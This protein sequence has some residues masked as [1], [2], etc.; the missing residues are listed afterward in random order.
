MS[1]FDTDGDGRYD[2]DER[3][4]LAEAMDDAHRYRDTGG[5]D[6]RRYDD[7]EDPIEFFIKVFLIGG[8]VIALIVAGLFFGAEQ[9]D[10]WFGWGLEAWLEETLPFGNPFK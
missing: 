7:D 3:R 2:Y 5:R 6:D 10:S 1:R 9:L 4:H 8:I